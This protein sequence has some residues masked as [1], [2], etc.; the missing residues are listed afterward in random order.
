MLDAAYLQHVR[1]DSPHALQANMS[2]VLAVLR[3]PSIILD[4]TWLAHLLSL[5]LHLLSYTRL[6]DMSQ[7]KAGLSSLHCAT[8]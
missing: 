1:N 3:D 7:G 8:G 6:L 4:V 2:A 5:G